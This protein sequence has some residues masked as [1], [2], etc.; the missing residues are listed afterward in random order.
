ML[1]EPDQQTQSLEF[2]LTSHT[3]LEKN[4]QCSSIRLAPAAIARRDKRVTGE[5]VPKTRRA[6]QRIY[7]K[8]EDGLTIRWKLIGSTVLLD[9]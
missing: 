1:L 8:Y 2:S 4:T 3:G 9:Q 5:A 7:F 6:T